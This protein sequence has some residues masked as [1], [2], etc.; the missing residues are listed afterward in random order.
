MKQ[1]IRHLALG[2]M[3]ALPTIASA[4]EY[5]VPPSS[6]GPSAAYRDCAGKSSES[7]YRA[8]QA[9]NNGQRTQ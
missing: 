8:A 3:L 7:A 5:Q 9:L 6:T 1:G 4:K 2:L